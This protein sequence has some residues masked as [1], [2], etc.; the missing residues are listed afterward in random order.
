MVP[1]FCADRMEL[2]CGDHGPDS[3]AYG[4]NGWMAHVNQLHVSAT[5][6]GHR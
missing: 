6:V 5:E 2:D 4:M 1:R 3:E